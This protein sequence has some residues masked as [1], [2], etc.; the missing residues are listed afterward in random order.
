M[1]SVIVRIILLLSEKLC[2]CHGAYF[3]PVDLM[4]PY[5]QKMPLYANP[6]IIGVFSTAVSLI[7]LGRYRVYSIHILLPGI[8]YHCT[9]ICYCGVLLY[10]YALPVSTV[11]V[12]LFVIAVFSSPSSLSFFLSA[13]G[14]PSCLLFRGFILC[15]FY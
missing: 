10:P 1:I 11:Y 13:A 14:A 8:T 5:R 12:S 6:H 3:V 15:I 7:T 9:D 2:V 4:P